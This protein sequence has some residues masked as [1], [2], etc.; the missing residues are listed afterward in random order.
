MTADQIRVALEEAVG[1]PEQALRDA[2]EQAAAFTPA[3]IAVVQ[4]MADGR[5]PLPHEEKLLRFGLHALSVARA[6]SACPAFLALL[7]RPVLELEW[8]FG[9]DERTNRVARLLLGLFDGDDAALRAVAADNEVDGDV[10]AALLLALARLVWD[11]RASRDALVD[12]LDRFDREELAAPASWAWYGWQAAI[13]LL[14]LTD[15]VERVQAA[16]DAGREL[17]MFD[18]DV[19]RQ[20]WPDDVRAAAAHPDDPQRFIDEQ[21]LPFDDPVTDI[22]WSAEPAGAQGDALSSDE[23]AW[24]NMVLWRRCVTGTMCLE[25]A[26]GFL[27]ALAVGAVHPPASEYLPAIWGDHPTDPLFDSP[28]HDATVAALLERHCAAIERDLAVGE[29]IDPCFNTDAVDLQG[30]LWAHGYMTGVKMCKEAWQPL[31]SRKRLAERLLTPI[32][33]LLLDPDAPADEQLL[34]ERRWELI[35]ELP[36]IVA[37]TW[38]FWQG[39]QHAVLDVPRERGPKIGR[40]DPCPCGSG[41]KYKKCCAAVA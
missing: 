5:L 2:V 14:G 24:L 4:H 41:M 36:D 16:Q 38:S 26:D 12:L 40:N 3:V 39:E 15:W 25:A 17:P 19:D 31:F 13:M 22:G 11:G 7:R 1:I 20:A 32:A 18:R 23:L 10:R 9:D 28:E 27:T 29:V 21:L 30:A 35:E 8:L 6:T 34:P 37:A 33:A